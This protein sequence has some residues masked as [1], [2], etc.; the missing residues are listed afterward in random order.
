[1]AK[2]YYLRD[3]R[4][5]KNSKIIEE[6][7]LL[8]E[9]FE[10]Y[11]E[12]EETE[13]KDLSNEIQLFFNNIYPK[14]RRESINEWQVDYTK[15]IEILDDKEK[16]KCQLCNHDIK[17]VCHIKNK[18]NG[19]SLKVG[20]ECV[21]HFEFK[22][23]KS[24]SEILQEMKF[25]KRLEKL[26]LKIPNIEKIVNQWG[27][28]IEQ[29][30]IYI[31]ESVKANYL[32]IGE[33]IKELY[34]E[35]KNKKNIPLY[36]EVEII[37]AIKQLL[38]ST[39]K[40][41]Q[42]I[43]DYVNKNKN[44]KLIPTKDIIIYLKSINDVQGLKWLEEDGEIKSR[45]LFRIKDKEYAKELIPSFNSILSREGIEIKDIETPN[46]KLGYSVL[47]NQNPNVKLFC[48]YSEFTM[49]YGGI[50]TGEELFLGISQS[51]IIKMGVLKD[52]ESIEFALGRIEHL[53]ERYSIKYE[54]FYY[55]FN[56]MLWV[57]EK[58]GK[59]HYYILTKLDG[60]YNLLKEIAY[61]IKKYDSKDLYD[62]VMKNSLTL[63]N[64]DADELRK[65]RDKMMI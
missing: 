58:K 20:T 29:Q 63:S 39:E 43:L 34:N 7:A 31:K 33:Q 27:L 15:P 10:K 21:K 14:I 42:A 54:E 17:N 8:S 12:L 23:D 16:I 2:V 13:L 65:T 4:L 9:A 5:I 40:E 44:N 45:T 62:I 49:G 35:Y 38:K 3:M 37:N 6:H 51:E 53:F 25:I 19:N 48:D 24:L 11:P 36:R 1:M 32:K 41:K 18:F 55:S 60:L 50:I 56:E 30:P 61:G 57:K 46:N 52:I 28:I 22:E 47:I 59:E 26:N 64:S